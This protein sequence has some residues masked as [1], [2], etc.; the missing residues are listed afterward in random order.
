MTDIIHLLPDSIANQ[1]AAGEVI[2]RPSSVVK[3]LVENSIDAGAEHIQIVIK[4]AGRTLITVIDDGK[5]MSPTD[6]R[7]AFERHATSKIK[8][9]DDLFALTT[10]GFRGEALPSIAAISQV[11]EG[12]IDE[13]LEDQMYLAQT[14]SSIVLALRRKVNIRVRQPLTKIMIPVADENQ[15]SN[16]QAV[17]QLILNEVNVKELAYVDSA[18]EIL[19]KRAKPDFKK[20]GPRYGKIMK[21]LAVKI[22]EFDSK[23]IQELEKNGSYAFMIDSQEVIVGLDD[24]EIIS[25]DIPGWLVENEGRLTVAL[26]I[27]ITDELRKEGIARELVN[28]IQNLRKAKDFEITDRIV[29]KIMSHPAI[30]EAVADNSEYIRNQ[31]LADEILIVNEKLE[32]EID[33]DDVS[34]TISIHKNS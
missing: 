25:E 9:A 23:D 13:Q 2:Q 30:D 32:D 34:L 33:I 12:L 6:A 5:G 4:D 10:M 19:V 16:L 21:Q 28:R 7:M 3:E 15:K 20:L 1:I 17:E 14:V 24:V 29:V 11:E 18:S 8:S 26:D 31:V 27:T 22:Q